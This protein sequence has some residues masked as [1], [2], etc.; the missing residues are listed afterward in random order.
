MGLKTAMA[1][2]AMV[3]LLA[4]QA[5]A[6]AAA[7][8]ESAARTTSRERADPDGPLR[9]LYPRTGGL[10]WAGDPSA[11]SRRTTVLRLLERERRLDPS[12]TLDVAILARGF[13]AA[14]AESLTRADRTLT[15]AWLGYLSR[16]RGSIEPVEAKLA[17]RISPLLDQATPAN[18]FAV[19]ALEL[20]L[21]EALGGWRSVPASLEPLPEP[22]LLDAA[23]S[24]GSTPVARRRLVVDRGQL[25]RRLVQSLDLP[26][27]YLA[28]DAPAPVLARAVRR[29]QERHG[30]PSDGVVGPR[31]LTALHEPAADQLARVQLNLARAGERDARASLH[32]YVEVNIPAFELRLVQGGTVTLRSRV[33][34]GD[35]KTPTPVFGDVIRYIELDPVWYVPPSIVSDVLARQQ[36]DSRYLERAGFVWQSREGGRP[37]LIQ[38]PGPENALGRFKFVFPNHHAVYLHDTAQR[39]LFGRADQALSHGCV[40]VERPAE[41]ALA[42][43]AEQGW[44]AARLEQALATRRTRRLDLVEPVPVFLDYRTAE[45]DAEGRLRLLADVYGHDKAA[46]ANPPSRP[47]AATSRPL[48][49]A[50][51]GNVLEAGRVAAR[52]ARTSF[53]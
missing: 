7:P 17:A 5:G 20:A 22:M 49:P 41:L 10:L 24:D 52:T 38:R 28:S 9:A 13:D 53:D 6:Q 51:D 40:R 36:R 42:L 46:R 14:E 19:A 31:T 15:R 25:Q 26:A 4:A 16:R 30:L 32:R 2:I 29:F 43:L 11:V 23:D 12:V 50:S 27:K 34:V 45:L 47:M 39:G 1:G 35:E 33:I 37:R 8:R 21:I 18:E 48:D 3:G 44:D